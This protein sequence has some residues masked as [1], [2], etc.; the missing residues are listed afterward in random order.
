MFLSLVPGVATKDTSSSSYS[1]PSLDASIN[2]AYDFEPSFV[3][4]VTNQTV[5][6]GR[7]VDLDCQVRNVRGYKVRGSVCTRKLVR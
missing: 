3:G 2:S 6:V 1:S 7:D 4:H 5:A